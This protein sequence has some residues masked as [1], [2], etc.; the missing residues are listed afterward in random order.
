M[1]IDLQDK[2]FNDINAAYGNYY[3]QQATQ[4]SQRQ[5]ATL[6]L[7]PTLWG[8]ELSSI[9]ALTDEA[10]QR[11]FDVV[12]N[13]NLNSADPSQVAEARM[14]LRGI[15]DQ[16][17]RDLR[18]KTR[19]REITRAQQYYDSFH[20]SIKLMREEANKDER[21][22]DIDPLAMERLEER[23]AKFARKEG[24]LSAADFDPNSVLFDRTSG[25][26]YMDQIATDALGRTNTIEMLTELDD[27]ALRGLTATVELEI[28]R[29]ME[30]AY[31]LAM[32]AARNNKDIRG[33]ANALSAQL[34]ITP[35]Q[36]MEQL[37]RGAIE[38]RS[39]DGAATVVDYT[40][41]N[42]PAPADQSR[43]SNVDQL[44]GNAKNDYI[45][46]ES[47]I[48]G[49]GLNPNDY[50]I[51]QLQ[52]IGRQ[53]AS[54]LEIDEDGNISYPRVD[55][56]GYPV[57]DANG[58]PVRTIIR[59][60]PR[61][62]RQETPTV[63]PQSQPREFVPNSETGV[64]YGMIRSN[65]V[66]GG[67]PDAV[68]ADDGGRP[69]VG[70]FQFNGN[71]LDRFLD[72]TYIA[73]AAADPATAGQA[74]DVK[75]IASELQQAVNNRKQ[76][77][78]VIEQRMA[79]REV[80]RKR[81]ELQDAWGQLRVADNDFAQKE[82]AWAYN[83]LYRPDIE[84]FE[85]LNEGV[86]MTPTIRTFLADMANQQ[87][88]GSRD[89]IIQRASR[90][91]TPEMSEY[92]V[93]RV[94]ADE[95]KKY[96]YPGT[97]KGRRI[98]DIV[99]ARTDRLV[100][101]LT[102]GEVNPFTSAQP[103]EDRE[104]A[105]AEPNSE[106]YI[107]EASLAPVELSV[108][109]GEEIDGLDLMDY[110][111]DNSTPFSLAMGPR[112]RLSKGEL[113]D[114]LS[115][116]RVTMPDGESVTLGTAIDKFNSATDKLQKRMSKYDMMR[117]NLVKINEYLE[118]KGEPLATDPDDDRF[119]PREL[120]TTKTSTQTVGDFLIDLEMARMTLESAQNE[121]AS[122]READFTEVK[123]A[124]LAK[125]LPEEIE[126]KSY[127]E[128]A[129]QLQDG[130]SI[131]SSMELSNGATMES[132]IVNRSDIIVR[133]PGERPK[134][135]RGFDDLVEYIEK[136]LAGEAFELM[137]PYYIIREQQTQQQPAAEESPAPQGNPFLNRGQ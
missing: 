124:I 26:A 63:T 67:N 48:S 79:D 22:L 40:I 92:D 43:T 39:R 12:K 11:S 132:S 44:T 93:L 21:T 10:R 42:Q 84:K 23:I 55:Q 91:I 82:E 54:D 33:M 6:G 115:S 9:N 56:D 117:G 70:S 110:L 95:R 137:P 89:E 66:G 29:E 24:S 111:I 96:N 36:A 116:A 38:Q 134:R 81:I 35:D 50:S 1:A 104:V 20:D 59:P 47:V 34:G 49:S 97:F 108:L 94:L 57:E 30:K 133:K 2:L 101:D 122:F 45:Q 127:E 75:R 105:T 123:G 83:N 31:Q 130:L 41:S 113:R 25:R 8:D 3:D 61:R 100:R 119:L 90:R 125:A 62:G 15:Q 7:D 52:E 4:R 13:I 69:S 80:E 135:L 118:E 60:Q 99:N 27:P 102:Q 131:E 78:G 18:D 112:A 65:E 120:A 14:E 68:V 51:P 87:G 37:V 74:R 5:E 121:V 107:D 88:Q 73:T 126:R 98:D 103:T 77:R 28:E 16:L 136:N 71:T 72:D 58:N 19:F 114:N 64:D 106:I 53:R 32:S 129:R 46:G 86:E 109:Q 76:A 17:S 85:R 128:L